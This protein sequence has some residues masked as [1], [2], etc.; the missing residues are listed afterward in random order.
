MLLNLTVVMY[1]LLVFLVHVLELTS[2][3]KNKAH[4]AK[5]KMTSPLDCMA[6]VQQLL[7][8]LGVCAGGQD[9]P[10]KTEF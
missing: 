3:M 6:T 2:Q 8:A 10:T 9:T 7:Q 4:R 5:I 1:H